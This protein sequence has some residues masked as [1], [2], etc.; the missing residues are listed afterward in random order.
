[1][2]GVL[3]LALKTYPPL[4]GKMSQRAKKK[5][6]EELLDFERHKQRIEYLLRKKTEY[7]SALGELENE[8]FR[9][10]RGVIPGCPCFT[11]DCL[12]VKEKPEHYPSEHASYQLER[13]KLKAKYRKVVKKYG[14]GLSVFEISD[15]E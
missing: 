4:L 12:C 10:I 9:N 2:S 15:D 1:M 3:E 14:A 7:Q 8:H 13:W 5:K 11:E 6:E